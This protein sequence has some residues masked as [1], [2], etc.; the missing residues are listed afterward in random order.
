MILDGFG[1]EA[2]QLDNPAP[3]QNLAEQ[4]QAASQ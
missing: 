4:Q 3:R 2:D 1:V